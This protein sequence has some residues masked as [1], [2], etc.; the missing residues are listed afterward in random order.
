MGAAVLSS[1]GCLR[2]GAGKL[3][4]YIP[5]CG[6]Q[7][8]QTAVP[9]AMALVSGEDIL[10]SADGIERF[11][12]VGIGPGIGMH[13]LHKNLLKAI[14]EKVK[15][16]MVIDADA[17]NVMAENKELLSLIP[18]R[19]IITPHPKEFERLFGKTENDSERLELAK[20][21]SKEYQV[22]IVLKGHYSFISTP[23]G[24]GYFN[25]T[26]NAGMATAGS[27]DVLTGMITGLLAQGYSPLESSLFGVYLHG[28]AGDIAA[29]E[30]S[31]EALIAGDIIECIGEAFKTLA[32]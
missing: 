31:L 21:R 15:A 22:Y 28:L 12:A 11:D 30:Y 5:Q 29:A 4:T 17:L 3:T 26:G 6:Y 8:L 27:G 9:E 18:A 7:V 10:V 2:S 1:M 16:P 32:H 20:Q 13:P 19:S 24:K 14:F 25:S 23:D